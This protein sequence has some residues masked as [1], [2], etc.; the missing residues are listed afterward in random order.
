MRTIQQ[1][2]ILGEQIL[3]GWADVAILWA[4]IEPLS[5]REFVAAGTEL[6]KVDTRIVVRSGIAIDSTMRVKHGDTLYEIIGVLPDKDSG[7]EYL[8][9]ACS[10]GVSDGR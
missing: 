4:A 2:P 9:L 6:S 3:Y 5:V 8:T 1:E 10:S 7:R